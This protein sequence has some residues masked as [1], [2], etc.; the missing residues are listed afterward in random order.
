MVA[1]GATIALHV[2]HRFRND[3]DVYVL[4]AT[5]AAG[6]GINLQ[7][8]HLMV[9][10]DLPWNPN[11]LE[12]RFGRIHRIGQEE[13]CHLW[14][15]IASNTR[16]GQVYARLLE[17]L[18]VERD[19]LNGKVFDVLGKLFEE[20][21][22]RSLLVRAIRYGDR[23][24]VRAQLQ[25]AVDN[26]MDQERVRDLLEQHALVQDSMDT[27]QIERVR[28]EMERAAARR[29][30]PY[31][32]KRF[33]MQAFEMLGGKVF[34][35]EP[36]RYQINH[37]PALIRDRARDIG[38]RVKLGK[39]YERICFEKAL[40]TVP[41][42]PNAE[43]ICPGHLLLDTVIDLVGRQHGHQMTDGLVLVAPGDF[44]KTPRALYYLE[45][46]LRDASPEQIVISR[47]IHFIEIGVDG[48]IRSAGIAPYVNYRPPTDIEREII[49]AL[50]ADQIPGQGAEA[51]AR[52]YAISDL[53]PRHL[54]TVR[55]RREQLIDKTLGAVQ[56]R[57][58]REINYWDRR[59]RDL[60]ED[61]KAGKRNATVNRK[62][63]QQRANDLAERLESRK[64]ELADQRKVVAAPPIIV[65][66]VLVVPMGALVAPTEEEDTRR[67]T[68]AAAMQTVMDAEIALGNDPRD[69]SREGI[70]YDIESRDGRSGRL[71][72]IEVKGCKAGADTVDVYHTEI[73]ACLNA[74]E[75]FLLAIV[76]ID[77]GVPLEPRYV[78]EPFQR[79][80]DE[81][82]VSVSFKLRDLLDQSSPPW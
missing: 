78:V 48:A 35:R 31:Y 58:T 28:E 32:I 67:I 60:R 56:A 63:A 14:N 69:V 57:L 40:I 80:P 51:Q 49:L 3:P 21:S 75:Q 76:E 11:R 79:E 73:L 6:E 55:E 2:E 82:T 42:K 1:S 26:A 38:G 4:L 39:A 15:L 33:F 64:R 50:P 74:R 43:F 59:A 8:A 30:Q 5:D 65:G 46:V 29:L 77:D 61:E 54:N 9:N 10:Y 23:P 72:F 19:S 20:E 44:S 12:Q 27:S 68:E 24:D 13:V 18:R 53:A 25:Q 22:L 41:G 71:R 36:G 16:E 45:H 66:R 47:E 7:R 37:V 17:K 70:G 34:E 81:R 52:S 62:R